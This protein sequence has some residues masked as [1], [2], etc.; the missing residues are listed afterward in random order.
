MVEGHL[1]VKGR[2]AVKGRFGVK[3]RLAVKGH[4]AV[5]GR[6][7]V[8]G[9][10]AVKGRLAVKGHLRLPLH[11]HKGGIARMNW[12]SGSAA[13]RLSAEPVCPWK[14]VSGEPGVVVVHSLPGFACPALW[15]VTSIH[16]NLISIL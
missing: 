11:L 1:T 16:L 2:L 9:Q 10:L 6:L 12:T 5:K 4:L 14:T 7:A 3:G 13:S 8:K 15:A